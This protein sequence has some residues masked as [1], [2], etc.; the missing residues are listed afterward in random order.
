MQVFELIDEVPEKV[1]QK[2]LFWGRIVGITYL[3]LFCLMVGSIVVD[4]WTGGQV[5]TAHL[6]RV[7]LI[8][9]LFLFGYQDYFFPTRVRKRIQLDQEHI[10]VQF[11]KQTTI[12][13]TWKEVVKVQMN[14]S[15]IRLFTDG[16]QY[17]EFDVSSLNHAQKQDIRK[18]L[19]QIASE[20]QIPVEIPSSIKDNLL[21]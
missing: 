15:A 3:V 11:A 18:T 14:F 6:V 9:V 12:N 10:Q 21:Q 7:V 5:K 19:Y 17:K 1:Y 16:H 8:S 2:K 13:L 20:K 4:I